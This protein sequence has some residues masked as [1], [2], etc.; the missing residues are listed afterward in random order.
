MQIALLQAFSIKIGIDMLWCS[1]TDSNQIA[2]EVMRLFVVTVLLPVE[3]LQ[4]IG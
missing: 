1:T 3:N 4:F 2:E